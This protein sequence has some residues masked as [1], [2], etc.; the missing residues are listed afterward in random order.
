VRRDV[1]L[2][3]VFAAAFAGLTAALAAGG[4]LVELDL[5]VHEW[6]Q[7]HRP[8]PVEAVA[9]GLNRLG[10]GGVLLAVGAILAGWLTLLRWW[11]ERAGWPAGLLRWRGGR[12][13]WPAALPLLY[14]LVAAG[15][16]YLTV[17]GTK[18]ATERGAPSSPLPPEQTVP[19]LGTLPPGE[20]A[21]GYPSGHAVNTIVWYGV[22]LLLATALLRAYRR[23]GPPAV[24]RRGFRVAPPVIVV[25]A[26]TY[27]SFHWLT[28]SLA[29]LALGLAIDRI[30]SLLRAG[31]RWLE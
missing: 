9:R 25:L 10:Q 29:G 23:P 21:T 24:A 19:L 2:V 20:Y 11:Q 1:L 17:A 31:M 13:G 28:D 26:Q 3:A 12:A 7:A 8:G 18:R 27:L 16:V 5:A 15:L 30:L 22:I 4:P 6:S 14:V